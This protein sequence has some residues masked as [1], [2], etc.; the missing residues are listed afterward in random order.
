[1][2]DKPDPPN[3]TAQQIIDEFSPAWIAFFDEILC[4]IE[5]KHPADPDERAPRL[6]SHSTRDRKGRANAMRKP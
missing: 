1:M 2:P 4:R 6:D 5:S 3:R